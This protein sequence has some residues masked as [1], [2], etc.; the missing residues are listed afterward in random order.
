MPPPELAPRGIDREASM[1][2]EGVLATLREN[3]ADID[4]DRRHRTIEAEDL[5]P[6]IARSGEM[7][8]PMNRCPIACNGASG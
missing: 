8:F 3:P 2:A 5:G 7:R 1:A 4:F 6:C